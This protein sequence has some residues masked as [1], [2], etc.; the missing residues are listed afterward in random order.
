M[1]VSLLDKWETAHVFYDALEDLVSQPKDSLVKNKEAEQWRD[2]IN[3]SPNGQLLVK[4]SMFGAL[5]EKKLWLLHF[6]SRFDALQKERRLYASGGCLVGSIYCTPLFWEDGALRLHNLGQYILKKEMPLFMEGKKSASPT[7]L[8]I[9]I[10]KLGSTPNKFA[11]LDYLRLGE[12][13][14]QIFKDLEYLLSKDERYELK[15]TVVTRIKNSID[16]LEVCNKIL[17][18]DYQTNVNKFFQLLNQTASCLPILGYTY[19]EVI[20]E[21]LQLYSTD[22]MTKRCAEMGEFNNWGYKELM[23]GLYPSLARDFNLGIFNP[24]P[25]KLR[26]HLELIKRKGICDIDADKLLT[27]IQKRLSFLVNARF[28]SNEA[29]FI[30]RDRLKLEFNDLTNYLGP[31]VG[32]LIHRELRSFR[33]YPDF[34]FYF[35]QLKALQVWNYWNHRDIVTPFNGVM[36]KGEIGINPAYPNLDY[37]IY[38]GCIQ[39]EGNSS[40]IQ[41]KKEINIKIIPRLVNLKHTLMRCKRTDY[42]KLREV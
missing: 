17:Y 27:Y 30:D 5:E 37:K 40:Y 18:Q 36:P 6:T 26:E 11:G 38:T 16:F 24:S 4:N 41:Q 20:A 23:F 29:E 39:T 10:N 31:L 12:I 14:L 34:Y 3:E 22:K 33:R 25:K 2:L 15:N 9:E 8:I 1:K 42:K 13:H 35:D 28:F 7:S 19:F 32:H 21:Y